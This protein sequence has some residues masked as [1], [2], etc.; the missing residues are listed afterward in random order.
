MRQRSVLLLLAILLVAATSFAAHPNAE[1]GFSADSAYQ[2]GNL[3]AVNLFN[4]NVSLTI[5]LGQ[6]Y[7]VGGSVSYGFSLVYNSKVWD[8]QQGWDTGQQADATE[9]IPNRDSNAGLGWTLSQGRLKSSSTD[10]TIRYPFSYFSADGGEHG[11]SSTLHDLDEVP[12]MNVFY[13]RDGSNL[14]LTIGSNVADVELPDGTAQTF[15]LASGSWR[16]KQI[17]DRFKD[18][19]GA[20]VNFV[21]VSYLT[22]STSC[23]GASSVTLYSDSLGRT[24]TVCY[25]SHTYDNTPRLTV[26]RVVLTS[27]GGGTARYQLS[28]FDTPVDRDCLDTNGSNSATIQVPLLTGVTMPQ[29][30]GSSFS[31]TYNVTADS[32][33]CTQ[34]IINS[35][36]LPTKGQIGWTWQRY[37]LP[38]GELDNCNSRIE[39]LDNVTGIRTKTTRDAVGTE[40]AVWTYESLHSLNNGPI[41]CGHKPGTYSDFAVGASDEVHTVVTRPDGNKEIHY[42][43]TWPRVDATSPNGG[44]SSFYGLPFTPLRTE[45]EAPMAFSSPAHALAVAPAACV[46]DAPCFPAP[47]PYLP[48]YLSEEQQACSAGHCTTLRSS[49]VRYERDGPATGNLIAGDLNRRV[50]GSRTVFHDDGNRFVESESADW[51]GLGHYRWTSQDGFLGTPVTGAMDARGS[52]TRYNP[53][54]GTLSY[55]PVTRQKVGNFVPPPPT[56]PWVL[57]TF[58]DKEMWG[59]SSADRRR[60][61]FCFDRSTG[62]LLRHRT[63]NGTSPATSD[64][65]EVFSPNL[66]GNVG[67]E[68]SLGGDAHQ[69]PASEDLCGLSIP[70][71]NSTTY[72]I[73]YLYPYFDGT[74]HGASSATYIQSNGAALLKTADA[75]IDQA[76]GLASTVRDAASVATS[77]TY[78]AAGRITA[79][80]PAAGHDARTEYS[81]Q[82]ASYVSPVFTPAK[83]GI[84]RRS[85][86]GI[87]SDTLMI[88]QEVIFDALGR[89]SVERRRNPGGDWS[90]H[91]TSYDSSGR[92]AA[93]SEWVADNGATVLDWTSYAYDLFGRPLMVIPPDGN[94]HAVNLYYLGNRGI[95]KSVAV[96]TGGDAST[97]TESQS[98]TTEWYDSFGRLV[99]VVEP[100]NP[101]LI[102]T[103]GYDPFDHLVNVTL[104]NNVNTAEKQIRSFVYDGRD[105]LLAETHPEYGTTRYD[106]YDA[107]GHLLRKHLGAACNSSPCSDFDLRYVYDGAERLTLVGRSALQAGAIDGTR[108]WKELTYATDNAPSGCTSAPCQWQ[109]GKLITS[110]RHN[111]DAN[112]VDTVVQEELQ[113]GGRGGR[114]S[115][116][117]TF[118]PAQSFATSFIWNEIGNVEQIIYPD[119]LTCG[120]G[121]PRTVPFGYTKGV[122]TIIGGFSNQISYYPNGMINTLSHANGVYEAQ[123][124]GAHNMARPDALAAWNASQYLFATGTYQYDGAGNIAAIGSN[125]YVYDPLSRLTGGG[126]QSG[127]RSQS[128]TFDVFGNMTSVATP[129]GSPASVPIAIDSATNHLVGASYDLAGNMT[130]YGGNSYRYDPMKMLTWTDRAAGGGVSYLYTAE[131]E[132]F[133]SLWP[134]SRTDYTVRGLDN[135]TLTTFTR[136]AAAN[137]SR[138]DY[139]YRAG[140]LLFA[141][142]SPAGIF[143]YLLDHLGTPRVVTNAAGNT[144]E[145]HDYFPFG[146]EATSTTQPLAERMQ[147]TGHERDKFT[148]ADNADSLDYMHARFYGAGWGRFMSVDPGSPTMP[149][150]QSWNRYAYALNN[151]MRYTDPTG[152]EVKCETVKDDDGTEQQICSE[153]IEVN[154][155]EPQPLPAMI[156]RGDSPPATQQLRI[157]ERDERE[158][159]QQQREAQNVTDCFQNNRF[160]SL[161]GGGVA[162]DVVG[163]L[164]VGS[165]I[166]LASDVAATAYKATQVSL[167][168]QPYASGVNYGFRAFGRAI[169]NPAL[170]R[171]LTKF[172]DKATP[173]LAVFGAFTGAYN[174]TIYLQCRG[175]LLE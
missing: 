61:Q 66:Y 164:E 68:Q 103:Y 4:G 107:H 19:A 148:A 44:D 22:S 56:A 126:V 161:F 99:S 30:D 104:Q 59:S 114:P 1:R 171:S 167:G 82:N 138:K 31:F 125:A 18:G 162:R 128:Y 100:S 72:R 11:F 105:L 115:Y 77:L 46:P 174:A 112:G 108:L 65:L 146:L 12:A 163:F 9:A 49:Y 21:N 3:D 137:W 97:I 131:D 136:D 14:R 144:A 64:L 110:R 54:A 151:S 156:A 145:T 154:G 43:S 73:D 139:I 169:E 86:E 80:I 94:A 15:E 106:E 96:R 41:Y 50:A 37:I 152:R 134:A 28:Y 157:R 109:R 51:D 90:R 8:Y 70:A 53:E 92:K 168:S 142:V 132:R 32:T 34:G 42:F 111:Y 101:G 160:S 133:A 88:E 166:S 76:T 122:M 47:T 116:R 124:Q 6:R 36:T 71:R 141:S 117:R 172:G 118:V 23:P 173:A 98:A 25:Q 143:H 58:T 95:S 67:S 81:Y 165:E 153:E 63:L 24:Q 140:G 7:E 75:D 26:D 85:T 74:Y 35:A 48:R 13:T 158:R 39:T 130:Q 120:L 45:L 123:S 150:P 17:H 159:V 127:L 16:L 62:F 87:L 135:K 29:P 2:F 89:L 149:S 155:S 78:D 113:Y 38:S 10:G 40:L 60:E 57:G 119:C 129:G 20:Y 91:L 93:V 79:I 83:V 69:V 175:G 84:V 121:T 102:A 147:Y 27:F 170:G 52:F 5:P 55:D 33:N